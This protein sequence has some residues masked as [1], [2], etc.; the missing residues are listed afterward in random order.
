ML[1]KW[2]VRPRVRA[3]WCVV[4]GMSGS[5]E[6]WT[7]IG[8]DDNLFVVRN[9]SSSSS[10]SGRSVQ[11]VIGKK[12]RH[13]QCTCVQ[14]PPG[15]IHLTCT[16]ATD[17]ISDVVMYSVFVKAQPARCATNYVRFLHATFLL[18]NS[19]SSRAD[20]TAFVRGNVNCL[21][22]YNT[23]LKYMRDVWNDGVTNVLRTDEACVFISCHFVNLNHSTRR[24]EVVPVQRPVNFY[25]NTPCTTSLIVA[26]DNTQ[27]RRLDVLLQTLIC[28]DRTQ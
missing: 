18:L 23:L 6:A 14:P 21:Y 5:G 7:G 26:Q 12:H 27:L 1:L 8:V 24:R 13:A 4:F 2:S 15:L 19:I 20:G 28:T 25:I 22:V 16:P 11:R 10:S 3:F 9:S 17:N